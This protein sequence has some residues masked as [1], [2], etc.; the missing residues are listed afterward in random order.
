M[1]HPQPPAPARFPHAARR[2]APVRLLLV[3]VCV[4]GACYG[5]V[6]APPSPRP[7]APVRIELTDAG[8]VEVASAVGPG[9]E[10]IDG[11]L[12]RA[13]ADSVVVGVTLTTSRRGVET[14]WRGER[15]AVPRTAVSSLQ[16]RRLSVVRTTVATVGGVAALVATAVGFDLGNRSPGASGRPAPQPQ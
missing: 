14:D 7:D 2:A 13:D 3:A 4:T 9:M 12:L 15:I 1:R 8:T 16:V 10:M 6:P 5:Y 11:R